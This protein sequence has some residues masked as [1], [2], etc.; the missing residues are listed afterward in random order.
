MEDFD[1]RGSSWVALKSMV[2]GFEERVEDRLDIEG[3]VT[4]TKET[5]DS[6]R[7]FGVREEV[8]FDLGGQKG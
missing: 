7:A 2:V 1:L 8:N 4:L 5:S 3:L 6:F